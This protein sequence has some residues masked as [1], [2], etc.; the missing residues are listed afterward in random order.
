MFLS[1][2]YKVPCWSLCD[3]TRHWP[4]F[5]LYFFVFI[6]G[7]SWDCGNSVTSADSASNSL[8][9]STTSV[10]ISST[11]VLNPSKSSVSVGIIFFQTPVNVDVLTSSRESWIFSMEFSM[12]N[13][14]QKVFS[15]LSP[16]PSEKSLAL[17]KCISYIIILE[18]Q[19]YSLIQRLQTDVVLVGLEAT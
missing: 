1:S 11:E 8:A 10:V 3:A 7:L 18:N 6:K 14:F 4:N 12:V 19:S 2:S 17:M 9:I 15:L 16:D 13:P 5:P